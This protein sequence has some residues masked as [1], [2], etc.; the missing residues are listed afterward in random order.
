MH[1]GDV[2]GIPRPFVNRDWPFRP[3]TSQEL[4]EIRRY[5]IEELGFNRDT[6]LRHVDEEW[7]VVLDEFV[8]D[9][10]GYRGKVAFALADH[11]DNWAMYYWPEGKVEILNSSG[12]TL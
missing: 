5:H 4:E 10:K 9:D 12:S 2:L 6:A 8:P 11:V 3:P 1:K 7:M